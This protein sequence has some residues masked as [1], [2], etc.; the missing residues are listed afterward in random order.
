MIP[1]I[2]ESSRWLSPFSDTFNRANTTTMATTGI[3]WVETIPD[4]QIVSNKAYTA[5]AT[6]SYP[7]LSFDA[8]KANVTIKATG[9]LDGAGFGVAFWVTN[10]T[11][12]WA[13]VTD[14][15]Q[16]STSGTTYTCPNGGTLSG[17]TCLKTCYQTCYETCYNQCCSTGSCVNY[18]NFSYGECGGGGYAYGCYDTGGCSCDAYGGVGDTSTCTCYYGGSVPLS[19]NYSAS[20][21]FQGGGY[22]FNGQCYNAVASGQIPA[23]WYAGTITSYVSCNPYNCN[24]YDCNPYAC[25]YDAT[26]TTS[27]ITTYTHTMKLIRNN[28]GTISTVA[29][30]AL[31][32]DNTTPV[33][34]TSI[35]VNTNGSTI[36]AT[37]LRGGVSVNL[38]NSPVSP[39]TSTRHGFI[40]APVTTT[41]L[42]SR[43]VDQ[44]D[45]LA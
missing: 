10:A 41:A 20:Q 42:L 28:A 14:V 16:G 9:N 2:V 4:W 25:N 40:L 30:V 29:T 38:T 27:T 1:G 33:Y 43:N 23:Y 35:Q 37:A 5:T 17:S 8:T 11:N 3:D 26:G 24:P 12:W 19:V 36:S 22:P 21:C 32:V 39:T 18:G 15:T 7:L 34:V 6:S 45:Y 13:V 44:F 31:G